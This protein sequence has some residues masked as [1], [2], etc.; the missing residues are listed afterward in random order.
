M[1]KSF[2][3][4][5]WLTKI[6]YFFL[7]LLGLVIGLIVWFTS[8]PYTEYSYGNYLVYCDNGKTFDP[9]SIAIDFIPGDNILPAEFDDLEIKSECAYGTANN[10]IL[11]RKLAKNY[12][13]TYQKY[14][15]V[16]RTVKDQWTSTIITLIT[17]YIFLEVLR[18]TILHVFL[19][20]NFLTLK[21]R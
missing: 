6:V 15:H 4:I 18:R 9:T 19:G 1:K 5:W 14:P 3:G 17:Y 20:R 16:I 10:I 7:L 13:L 2:E 21:N 12:M 8:S 11:S